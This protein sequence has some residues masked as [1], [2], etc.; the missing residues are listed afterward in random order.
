MRRGASLWLF[1][2][3]GPYR[4]GPFEIDAIEPLRPSLF[5]SSDRVALWIAIWPL[6]LSIIFFLRPASWSHLGGSQVLFEGLAVTRLTWVLLCVALACACGALS[7]SLALERGLWSRLGIVCI[8]IF[9]AGW[10]SSSGSPAATIVEAIREGQTVHPAA[11][12]IAYLMVLLA[13]FGKAVALLGMAA[14]LR[15]S[16]AAESKRWRLGSALLLSGP[17]LVLPLNYALT[18][19][20]PPAEAISTMIAEDGE[21][22]PLQL[23]AIAY[24]LALLS[25]AGYLVFLLAAIQVL[26]LSF[27]ASEIGSVLAPPRRDSPRWT[28]VLVTLK[29]AFVM[30]LFAGALPSWMGDETSRWYTDEEI[31]LVAAFFTAPVF[32]VVG[33]HA[34]RGRSGNLGR[35][36]L[37]L[38]VIVSLPA[39]SQVFGFFVQQVI[40]SLIGAAPSDRPWHFDLEMLFT[41]SFV[42]RLVLAVFLWYRQPAASALFAFSVTVSAPGRLQSWVESPIPLPSPIH[43]DAVVTGLAV[44]SL[45]AGVRMRSVSY[46]RLAVRLSAAAFVLLNVGLFIPEG[47][48]RHLFGVG[49]VAAAVY[50]LWLRARDLNET[51]KR[52]PH[53]VIAGIAFAGIVAM[54]SWAVLYVGAR[55]AVSTARVT[56]SDQVSAAVAQVG[57]PIILASA[58][59]VLPSWRKS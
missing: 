42:S 28:W 7:W 25:A 51:A 30:A 39:T 31:W 58:C 16:R 17:L 6:A 8:G 34:S 46:S 50:P 21:A 55:H 9:V 37:V 41:A 59:A 49:V 56:W 4:L 26:E 47:L 11:K 15:R 19:L 22:F 40:P 45:V 27:G 43:L 35:W 18:L 14:S 54:V 23:D 32:V 57:I 12:N 38:A 48:R 52:H 2:R 24:P 3:R 13:F 1:R 29:I 33:L 53:R 10:V 36:P 5:E 20:I 44:L